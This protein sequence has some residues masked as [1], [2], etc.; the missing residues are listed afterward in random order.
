MADIKPVPTLSAKG[1]VYSIVEKVDILMAHFYASDANQD[2]LHAGSIANLSILLQESGNNL[3]QLKERVRATLEQYLG[4]YFETALVD[5]RDD[6]DTN[7]SNRVEMSISAL[8]TQD[9]ERYDVSHLLSL[10]DGKFEKITKL[11]NTGNTN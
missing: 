5:V 7:F 10:I 2:Y 4:R 1:M 11:N 9:G 6:A 3:P 8:V